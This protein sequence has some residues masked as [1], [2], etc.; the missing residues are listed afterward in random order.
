M[1]L[2]CSRF[3]NARTNV[4]LGRSADPQERV[5]G[6]SAP[7]RST[8]SVDGDADL[9]KR[10]RLPEHDSGSLIQPTG[11]CHRINIPT[12]AAYEIT[13][14]ELQCSPR[15]RCESVA[16]LFKTRAGGIQV[17]GRDQ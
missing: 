5:P 13:R 14:F 6:N 12:I 17:F 2:S 7:A 3:G 16:P 8:Y 11:S 15:G 10:R 1:K 4:A 9:P